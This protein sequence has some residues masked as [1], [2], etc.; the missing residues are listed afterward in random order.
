MEGF[1]C[2]SKFQSSPPESTLYS[3]HMAEP[4]QHEILSIVEGA[5]PHLCQAQR[6]DVMC[7]R[8]HSM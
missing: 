6:G 8:S 2:V 5:S 7:L 4:S 1:P 3:S